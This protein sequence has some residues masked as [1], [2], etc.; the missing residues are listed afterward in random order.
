MIYLIHDDE[1]EELTQL[2]RNCLANAM[3]ADSRIGSSH[4]RAVD[5]SGHPGS[6]SGRG[7]GGHCFPKDLAAF[8][9]FFAQVLPA[10]TNGQAFWQA[11]ENTN[12]ELLVNTQK[13]LDLLA[14]I[15]G[16]TS[17]L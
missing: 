3:S 12:T 17:R 4:M 16:D 2:I 14:G 13:D 5:Q 1:Y 9:S 11:L 6:V 10:H 7:A 15:Y 8:R